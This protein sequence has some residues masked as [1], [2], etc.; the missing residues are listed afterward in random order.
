MA[1]SGRDRQ[2]QA[3]TGR[4]RQG[5]AGTGRDRQGQAG[6]GRDRQGQAG[7]GRTGR[8]RQGQAGTG[9]D[10]QGQAGTGRDRQGQGMEEAGRD[11][12][13][14]E[15]KM[16][17][18]KDV[19]EIAELQHVKVMMTTVRKGERRAGVGTG[20]VE[21]SLG[22]ERNESVEGKYRVHVPKWNAIRNCSYAICP[23]DTG[24]R[25]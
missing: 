23:A 18:H 2:G 5:Q 19:V 14:E 25:I 9:R 16:M 3:W 4:D 21:G 1:I 22:E 12:P 20:A 11:L 15:V 24:H 6:T 13:I 17:Q 10:R 7:T 8:D